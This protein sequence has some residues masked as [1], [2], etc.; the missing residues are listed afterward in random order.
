MKKILVASNNENKIK[1]I[2]NILGN[3]NFEVL[4]LKDVEIDIEVE[5]NG[6]TF[7]ENALIKAREI[8]NI[9]SGKY[10]V[11]A[12]DSGLSVKALDGKP[13]IFSARYAG[14][15]GNSEKNNEKLLEEMKNVKKENREAKFICA[16]AIIDKEEYIIKEEVYGIIETKYEGNK[17]FGYDPLFY[18]KEFGKTFAQM[19]KE[20]KNEISHRGKALKKVREILKK[21]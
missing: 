20:E 9:T 4:S 6:E 5:E 21:L 3:L 10:I 2:K 16:I 7:E 14:E 15:H 19:S 1:E 18:Y 17:G 11:L 12:D 13:G 8:Y